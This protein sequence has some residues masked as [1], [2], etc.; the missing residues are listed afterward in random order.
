MPRTRALG[1]IFLCICLCVVLPLLLRRLLQ[2]DARVNRFSLSSY[3]YGKFSGNVTE[4]VVANT[5]TNAS[6]NLTAFCANLD[7]STQPMLDYQTPHPEETDL[8]FASINSFSHRNC[9]RF[10]GAFVPQEGSPVSAQETVYPLAFTI[11]AHR[12]PRQLARLL[13]MIHRPTNFYCI[14]ID[15]RSLPEFSQAVEGI[16]TC[17][18][19]NVHVVPP[20][21]R[22]VVTWGNASVLEPQLVCADMA[23]KQPGWRYLLNV[24]AEEVP[25]RTNLEIIAAMKALNGSNLME[26]FRGERFSSWTKGIQLPNQVSAFQCE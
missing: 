3:P 24:A 8:F 5:Q 18:G 13:R 10:R 21:S 2:G 23:L 11:V 4:K 26:C 14:H 17:F 19:P 25:L 6:A 7:D 9:Q 22:V 1:Y 20:E 16:A 12:N 15:R